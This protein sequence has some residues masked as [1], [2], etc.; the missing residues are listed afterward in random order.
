M[1]HALTLSAGWSAHLVAKR[2]RVAALALCF[3]GFGDSVAAQAP[4]ARRGEAFTFAVKLLGSVDAGRAR[5]ALSPPQ[6]SPSGAVVRVVGQSEALGVAKALTGWRQQYNLALDAATLLPKRIEQVDSGRTPREALFVVNGR[7]FDMTVKKPGGEWHAKGELKSELL[8]PMA[9]LL[10]LRTV[11]LNDGDRLSLV[12]TGGTAVYRST[13]TVRG[14]EQ[15]TTFAGPRRAIHLLGRGERINERD[16]VIGK[17]PWLGDVWLSDD[18]A[19]LPLRISAETILGIAEFTL[20]SY[21]AGT[22]PLALPRSP[23]GIV[24]EPRSH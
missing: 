12:V 8:D 19:R 22:R 2:C 16:E 15:L 4:P 20:T 6:P 17:S 10:L 5:L 3:V 1:A 14:R 11:K 7:S 24:L 9:V 21:E 13:L 18:S 23:H